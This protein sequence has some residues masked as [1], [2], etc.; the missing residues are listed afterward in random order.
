[1]PHTKDDDANL[2]ELL[3]K[4]Q[5][6]LNALLEVTRAIN[7]NKPT[8][9]LL[10]MLEMIMRGSLKVGR[11]RLLVEECKEFSCVCQFGG[12]MESHKQ[13]QQISEELMDFTTPTK[14]SD[15]PDSLLIIYD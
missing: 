5:S 12:V 7:N 14:L 15:H 8:Q 2:I 10:E 13:F 3:L 1:M 9:F 6:E 11:F 4:R